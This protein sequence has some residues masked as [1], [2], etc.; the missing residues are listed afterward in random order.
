MS[1]SQDT[2]DRIWEE[3]PRETIWERIWGKEDDE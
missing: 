1:L 2:W 3:D